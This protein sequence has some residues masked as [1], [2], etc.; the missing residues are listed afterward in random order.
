MVDAL[1]IA[2]P[3]VARVAGIGYHSHLVP[4]PRTVILE[5]T[6]ELGGKRTAMPPF[7]SDVPIR[8]CLTKKRWS[9]CRGCAE[10]WGRPSGAWRPSLTML[11]S[12]FFAEQFLTA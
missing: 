10:T 12:C 9:R 5:P 6:A 8:F 7:P 4:V 3:R 2:E 1:R 11:S